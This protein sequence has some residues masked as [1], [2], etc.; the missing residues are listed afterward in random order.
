MLVR[1]AWIEVSLPKTQ[2]RRD[3]AIGCRVSARMQECSV[4]DSL[5][6]ARALGDRV[7]TR[8]SASTAERIESNRE[9]GSVRSQSWGMTCTYILRVEKNL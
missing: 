8:P 2:T 9:R 5:A 1:R 6:G 4:V 3:I 7:R